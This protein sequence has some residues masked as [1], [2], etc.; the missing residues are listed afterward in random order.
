MALTTSSW[1]RPIQ[2]VSQQPAK[3]RLPGQCSQQINASSSVASGLVKRPG[4]IWINK[5]S[6]SLPLNTKYYYYNRGTGEEYFV[7]IP[8]NQL[9]RVFDI[10]GDE[11]TVENLHPN[12]NYIYEDNP[13]EALNLTTISDYTFIANRNVVPTSSGKTTYTLQNVALINCQFADYGREYIV[14]IDGE[15]AAFMRTPDGGDSEHIRFVDTSTVAI[16][17]AAGENHVNAGDLGPGSSGFEIR[18]GLDTL[19]GFTV[20]RVGNVI[21][22]HRND[23]GDFD[24]VTQDGSDGRDLFGIKNQVKE[25]SDL[26]I[27]APEGYSV[28]VVGKG[29]SSDDDYWLQATS[30]D[31]DVVTWSESRGPDQSVGFNVDSMPSALVRDRFENGKAVFQYVAPP[32]AERKVGDDDS[33]PMPSFIQEGHS[34]TS[35]GTFQNR[36]FITAGESVIYSRS[37][38]FFDFFRETVRTKLDDDPI[39]VLAD[40]NNVNF[41]ENSS[42]L[43][44]DIVFFS[45]NGQFVQ[46]GEKPITKENA[47]LRYASVFENIST[48]RP[49]AG[50]NVV[51]FA[52]QYGNYSG[53][54]EFY[55]DS[56]TD[57]KRARPVTDHVDEYIAGSA[58]L[59]ATSTNRNHLLV[60]TDKDVD[61][62][63][64][65][66]WLW[67]DNE[68]V[69]SSWSKWVLDGTVHHVAFDSD[70]I[71]ILVEREDGLHLEY[72]LIGD[73][74]DEGLTF[75]SRLDQRVIVQATR[76]VGGTWT[77]TLP[78]D[79]PEE[80]LLFVRGLGTDDAGVTIPATVEGRDVTFTD[81]LSRTNSEV[82][83][84]VGRPYN[85]LYEPTMP[86]IKDRNGRVIETDRL[87]L[88]DVFINYDKTGLSK[89]TV[90]NDYGVSREYE[91]NGRR[92]GGVTNLVGFAPLSPGQFSFP[93]RQDSDRVT[94]R[95]ETM[96][97]LPFQLRDMEWR[98]RFHQRGRRV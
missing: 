49:V 62:I 71:Y 13:A 87:T 78:Y 17:L 61:T 18:G 92:I 11:L 81:D 43:D 32:Y 57:T 20:S 86:Y 9:P 23:Y 53:I 50:G 89:V 85:L 35:L 79:V 41:L 91:F 34:I 8:P 77:A 5:L 31:G 60:L 76:Q 2:G 80:D 46:F 45:P 59:L 94:F 56:F 64:V 48:C 90:E 42:V 24:L 21:M 29:N 39:D 58:R 7:L 37:N 44:G 15:E 6:D 30:V 10:E 16:A 65:F 12:A 26:P 14:S 55:T 69:Q 28:K 95:I 70:V 84:I 73:P 54:R 47:S 96:S 67:Q 82:Y 83:V 19:E 72:I 1:D 36:L 74:D 3:V 33:N 25:V 27:W 97:H 68:R 38:Y 75:A 52:F 40:T 22:L 63:Y 66:E 4:T 51:F 88:N 93:V 98:G